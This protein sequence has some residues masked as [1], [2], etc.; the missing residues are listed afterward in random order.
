MVGRS[1]GPPA[2]GRAKIARKWRLV[3][4]KIRGKAA[5]RRERLAGGPA[6]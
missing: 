3:I 2:A 4:G 5:R 1:D 6:A